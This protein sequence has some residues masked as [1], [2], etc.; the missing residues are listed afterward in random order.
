VWI[1]M[2][3]AGGSRG[4]EHVLHTSWVPASR[5]LPTQ[6]QGEKLPISPNMRTMKACVAHALALTHHTGH[7]RRAAWLGSVLPCPP[8]YL[9]L[10]H[11]SRVSRSGHGHM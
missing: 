11:N 4:C 1:V 8:G 3:I 10:H 9:H 5:T 6:S 7:R 2:Q